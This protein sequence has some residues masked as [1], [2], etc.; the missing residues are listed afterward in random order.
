MKIKNETKTEK[1]MRE[2]REEEIH[3]IRELI[4]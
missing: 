2:V 4:G 3:R 1:R